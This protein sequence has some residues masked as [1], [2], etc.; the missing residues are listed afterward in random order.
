MDRCVALFAA[1]SYACNDT[2]S[3]KREQAVYLDATKLPEMGQLNKKWNTCVG[4]LQ[5]SSDKLLTYTNGSTTH[6]LRRVLLLAEFA[7][8]SPDDASIHTLP[9]LDTSYQVETGT[10][11]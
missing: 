6:S 4:H 10:E 5:F 3:S 2:L 7:G 9:G 1:D 8:C 11:V